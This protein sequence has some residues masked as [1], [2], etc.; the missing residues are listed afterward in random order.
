[1]LNDPVPSGTAKGRVNE[2]DKMLPEYYEYRGWT[3]DGEPTTQTLA[4]LGLQDLAGS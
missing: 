2:L 1:M 4:R 3:P